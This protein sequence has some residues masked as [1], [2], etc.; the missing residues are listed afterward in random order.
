MQRLKLVVLGAFL[1]LGFGAYLSQSHI[2]TVQGR[3]TGGQLVAPTGLTASD[4]AYANKVGLRWDTI[5]DATLY[6]IFR[7][8]TAIPAT[9]EDIGTTPANYFF[10]TSAVASQTYYYWIRAENKSDVS[11]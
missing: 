1:V 2:S 5:R 4:G 8:T 10:D 7:G 3:T 11:P 9:A 6:R